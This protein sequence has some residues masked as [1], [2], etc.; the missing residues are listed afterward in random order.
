MSRHIEFDDDLHSLFFCKGD[1]V[2]DFIISIERIGTVHRLR[3]V[4]NRIGFAFDAPTGIV[5]NVPVKRV[6]FVRRQPPN[7]LFEPLGTLIIS[8]GVLVKTADSK[9]R[10]IADNARRQRLFSTFGELIQCQL[11]IADSP[12]RRGL[13][14][15]STVFDRAGRRLGRIQINRRAVLRRINA[16]NFF[17]NIDGKTAEQQN[18]RYQNKNKRFHGQILTHFRV[19]QQPKQSMQK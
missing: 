17:L 1:D 12:F 15:D 3:V 14:G 6:E 18:N 5:G 13:D 10:P 4:E 8:A 7:L 2:A 11:G 16:G 19:R 9:R